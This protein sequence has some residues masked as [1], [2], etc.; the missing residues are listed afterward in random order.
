MGAASHTVPRRRRASLRRV[1]AQLAKHRC[2]RSQAG[3][4]TQA[5]P[6]GAAAHLRAPRAGRSRVRRE[7]RPRRQQALLGDSG[8]ERDRAAAL[9]RPRGL[10]QRRREVRAAASR[11]RGCNRPRPPGVLHLGTGRT[12]QALL[13]S[14]CREASAGR[15]SA[16]ALRLGRLGDV[17]QEAARC[18][19]SGR[20]P[21]CRPTPPSWAA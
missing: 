9:L 4:R 3:R 1:R 8:A 2:R 19:S 6:R 16:R 21:A 18:S 11:H 14:A 13:R 17:R 5:R 10:S 12:H 20:A 15:R 7:R